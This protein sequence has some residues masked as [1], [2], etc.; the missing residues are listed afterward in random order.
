[1][2]RPRSKNKK[3]MTVFRVA[4]RGAFARHLQA[5]IDSNGDNLNLIKPEDEESSSQPSEQ[6]IISCVESERL[7]LNLRLTRM[8]E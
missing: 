5:Q 4:T 6:E 8:R 2:A 1:M 3:R 7:K